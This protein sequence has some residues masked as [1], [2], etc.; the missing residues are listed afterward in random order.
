M[1]VRKWNDSEEIHILWNIFYVTLEPNDV[2]ELEYNVIIP[3]TVGIP[4]SDR[5]Q[6]SLAKLPTSLLFQS[7]NPS[8]R[9]NF[10]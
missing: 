5:E 9:N 1:N 10:T 7:I 4:I 8:A 3:K 2:E 6:Q